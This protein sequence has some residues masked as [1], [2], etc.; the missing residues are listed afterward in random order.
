[1]ND[2][3]AAKRVHPTERELSDYLDHLATGE[4]KRMVEDHIA[5]CSECLAAVVCAYDSVKIFKK[6]DK[7]IKGRANIMK[8]INIYLTL[9]IVSFILSFAVPRYFAQFLVASTLLGIK[10]ISDAKST[11][12]LVMIY[13]AWKNGGEKE[14]SRVLSS[15]GSGAKYRF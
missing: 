4:A 14:A 5:C 8:K 9:A 3:G 1:M 10:W 15:L 13:D 11:R 7:N 2:L 6:E 12:M